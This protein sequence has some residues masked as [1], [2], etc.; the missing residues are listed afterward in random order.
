L[1]RARQEGTRRIYSVDPRGV[2]AMRAF[3]DKFWDDA[4]ASFEAAAR[5]DEE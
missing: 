1:V 5:E 2:M 4:L 3:L